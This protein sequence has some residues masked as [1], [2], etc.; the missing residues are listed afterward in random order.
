MISNTSTGVGEPATC[1]RMAKERA[2]APS[3]CAPFAFRAGALSSLTVRRGAG[4]PV[5]LSS[6]PRLV[7][8]GS[9]N[10]GLSRHKTASDE[11]LR[12]RQQQDGDGQCDDG[13]GD[14][15]R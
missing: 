10:L 5:V 14:G 3:F 1:S 6:S 2:V 7:R 13:P 15:T 9:P 8:M 12:K 11:T 4:V